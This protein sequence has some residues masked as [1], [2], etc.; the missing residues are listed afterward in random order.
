MPDLLVRSVSE[1]SKKLL[2]LRAAQNN[3]SVQAE[4]K[5]I[6]EDAVAPVKSGWVHLLRAAAVDAEAD[7]FELPQR[8]AARE[9]SFDD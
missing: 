8:H 2:A 5:R 3:R 9:Y 6:L 7:G 4:A 1:E